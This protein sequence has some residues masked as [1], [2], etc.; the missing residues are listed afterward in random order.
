MSKEIII[1]VDSEICSFYI[2]LLEINFNDF[3]YFLKYTEKLGFK[4]LDHESK[5]KNNEGSL[6]KFKSGIDF[7][8]FKSNTV[9]NFEKVNPKYHITYIGPNFSKFLS[10]SIK[11]YDHTVSGIEELDNLYG[12]FKLGPDKKDILQLEFST[13]S[14]KNDLKLIIKQLHNIRHE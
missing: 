10:D 1:S 5:L 3:Y 11:P 6:V 8:R 7:L 14:F 9:K 2:D 13:Y 12:F 4:F